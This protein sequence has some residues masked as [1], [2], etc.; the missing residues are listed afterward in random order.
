MFLFKHP[1]NF[2]VIILLILLTSNCQPLTREAEEDLLGYWQGKLTANP[3]ANVIL[4][5]HRGDGIINGKVF[6]T[7]NGNI[8]SEDPMRNFTRSGREIEFDIPTQGTHYK[9]KILKSAIEGGFYTPNNP[10]MEFHFSKAEL[11]SLD[12]ADKLMSFSNIYDLYNKLTLSQLGEDFQILKEALVTH[13]QLYLYNAREEINDY[14]D[15]I[16]NEFYE[17]MRAIDFIRII[18]PAIAKVRCYHTQLVLPEK[19]IKAIHLQANLLP[20]E[21][22]IVDDKAFVTKSFLDKLKIKPG[23][24]I[25]E[26]ND[27]P[28]K[29]IIQKISLCVSSDGYNESHIMEEINNNFRILYFFI[30]NP[31]TYRLKIR[32]SN[33]SMLDSISIGSFEP[34]D[35]LM[36]SLNLD[37]EKSNYK[38]GSVPISLSID[39]DIGILTIKSFNYYDL[40]EYKRKMAD[41]FES[42]RNKNVNHLIIDLRGNTGGHPSLSADLLRYFIKEPCR[43]FIEP[44]DLDRYGELLRK[45]QPDSNGF[46]G[47]S[48][49]ISDGNSLSS[50]GHFLALVRYLNLGKIVGKI[51]G[52]SFYCN[53]ETKLWELPNS[54]VKIAVAQTTF[55]VD[56]KGFELGDEIIPDLI[57]E[58]VLSDFLNEK[59]VYMKAVKSLIF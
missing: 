9:G 59:D 23:T 33:D 26:I 13:P 28:V 41:V 37:I 32:S 14:F 1:S 27:R 12:C 55:I 31:D 45:I 39:N 20:L 50:T 16:E 6:F 52:G 53:D 21:L 29:E 44:A 22:F 4:F 47:K 38:P 2:I 36:D 15:N 24:E 35:Y 8:N 40:E 18:A 49:F 34:S 11:E 46:G 51:P 43:Y 42:L 10:P 3:K 5:F 17:G 48:Y 54:Q 19:I 58:P 25:I 56:V 57:V 30:E 7:E